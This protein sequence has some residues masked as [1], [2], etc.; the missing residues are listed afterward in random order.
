MKTFVQNFLTGGEEQIEKNLADFYGT[1]CSV[2]E[3]CL[4]L[5]GHEQKMV[6]HSEHTLLYSS[7]L[8]HI[9]SQET[10]GGSNIKRL[11]QEISRDA[12]KRYAIGL[13]DAQRMLIRTLL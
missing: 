1:S 8:L 7:A 5:C 2:C 10:K 11:F 12:L 4:M 9:L 6:C 13:L 3:S